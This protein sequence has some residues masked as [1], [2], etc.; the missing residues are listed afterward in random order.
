MFKPFFITFGDL[1]MRR[2]MIAFWSFLEREMADD[3]VGTENM[4]LEGDNDAL[5][6]FLWDYK[7]SK[8]HP[9]YFSLDDLYE[10][11]FIITMP[12]DTSKTLA[13]IPDS[14]FLDSNFII[15]FLFFCFFFY[16]FIDS[17]LCLIFFFI[18]YWI[19]QFS[20]LQDIIEL[21]DDGASWFELEY[22]YI[23]LVHPEFQLDDFTLDNF[24]DFYYFYYERGKSKRFFNNFDKKFKSFNKTF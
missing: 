3:F 5:Q 15:D 18:F 6:E 2:D 22:E 16:F 8:D 14:F 23:Y 10:T 13:H 12:I 20:F 7:D 19:Y 24:F 17:G 21:E 4:T 1:R 11:D 9:D